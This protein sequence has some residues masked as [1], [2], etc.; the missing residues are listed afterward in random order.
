[1]LARTLAL[2]VAAAQWLFPYESNPFDISKSRSSKGGQ[3]SHDIVYIYVCRNECIFVC[4]CF[5]HGP[6]IFLANPGLCL[7]Y[8]IL[9]L[10]LDPFIFQ[11]D[12]NMS[13]G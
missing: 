3:C 4:I 5:I 11:S 13:V 12:G 2:F 6:I 9:F 8:M 10:L 1:V 7:I